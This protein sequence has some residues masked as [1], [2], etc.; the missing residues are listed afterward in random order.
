MKTAITAIL[1][2]FAIIG[3]VYGA[4]MILDSEHQ[5]L[6]AQSAKALQSGISAN[7]LQMMQWELKDILAREAAG[8]PGPGDAARK[9]VLIER[10]KK[11]AAK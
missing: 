2:V 6:I 3:S 11:L 1:G 8:T 7:Q 10:I 4:K 5:L 9:I